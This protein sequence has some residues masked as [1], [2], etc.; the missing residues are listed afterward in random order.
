MKRIILITF[1]L[2]SHLSFSQDWD[3]EKPNYKKLRKIFKIRSQ[4]FFTKF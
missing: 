1:I 4:I 2:M 3:F